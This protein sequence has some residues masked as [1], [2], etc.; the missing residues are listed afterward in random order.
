MVM[1]TSFFISSLW[2]DGSD[3][4]G[5]EGDGGVKV[6]DVMLAKDSLL[7]NL[8]LIIVWL[9]LQASCSEE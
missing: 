4:G 3:G 8:L 9:I 1:S 5:G 6:V 7:P 2:E